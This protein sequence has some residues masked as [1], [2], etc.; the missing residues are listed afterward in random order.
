MIEVFG[1]GLRGLQSWSRRCPCH[2]LKALGLESGTSYY[3]RRNALERATLDSSPC[4]APG[5]WAPDLA[6]GVAIEVLR[7][8]FKKRYGMLLHD[9]LRLEGHERDEIMAE[10]SR[11]VAQCLYVVGLKTSTWQQIPL[12]LFGIAHRDCAKASAAAASAL[13]QLRDAKDFWRHHPLTLEVL[14]DRGEVATAI[15][16]VSKGS[17]VQ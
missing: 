13:K 14:R 5:L 16:K 4:A 12:V 2:P 9:L 17:L 10:Y 6:C 11:G 3:K 7:E 1:A 15:E 8:Q